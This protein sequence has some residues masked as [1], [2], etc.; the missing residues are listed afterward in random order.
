MTSTWAELVV[1]DGSVLFVD[2]TPR[3]VHAAAGE[4]V[5]IIPGASHHIEPAHD[6]AFYVQF[7]ERTP[8]SPG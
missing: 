6:A 3:R 7:Y 2:D 8:E 5:P 1:L 4:R